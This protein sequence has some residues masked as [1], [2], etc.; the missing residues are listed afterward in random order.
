VK[1]SVL[2]PY[3]ELSFYN[4]HVDGNVIA[5]SLTT[6]L[7]QLVND[8]G[9]NYNAP[10]GQVNNYRFGAINVS[11]PASIALLFGAGCFMLAR[12]RKAN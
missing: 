1:G 11:E 8:Q 10:T 7:V 2:A 4:G 9:Q 3:A 5:N 12:R 6:P